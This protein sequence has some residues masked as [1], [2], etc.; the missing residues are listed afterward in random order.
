MSK[1]EIKFMTPEEQSKALASIA[2]R[3]KNGLRYAYIVT[4]EGKEQIIKDMKERKQTNFEI[5]AEFKL[6][7]KYREALKKVQ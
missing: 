3:L 6:L 7:D 5:V 2:D 1:A 4:G